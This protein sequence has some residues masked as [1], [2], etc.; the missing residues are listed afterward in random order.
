MRPTGLYMHT[1]TAPRRKPGARWVYSTYR[2]GVTDRCS[3]WLDGLFLGAS[4][5][6]TGSRKRLPLFVYMFLMEL[7]TQTLPEEID[8]IIS[9]NTKVVGAMTDNI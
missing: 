7:G 6:R 3:S 5:S 9:K 2:R 1:L 4:A 8:L